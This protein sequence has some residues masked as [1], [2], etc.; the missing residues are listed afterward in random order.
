[1]VHGALIEA[2]KVEKLTYKQ[3]LRLERE[4]RKKAR[5]LKTLE[6]LQAAAEA[7]GRAAQGLFSNQITGTATFIL[8]A[9]TLYPA[10]L[11]IVET[12]LAELVTAIS[13]AWKSG[14]LPPPPP[15]TIQAGEGNFGVTIAEA[16]WARFVNLFNPFGQVANLVDGTSWFQ[17]AQERD[18]YYDSLVKTPGVTAFYNI[19][20]VNR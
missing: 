4:D 18:S 20:K 17:T 6:V 13:N 3:V 10:W 9:A 11:P 7:G 1:M 19:T 5:E 16:Q 15:L 8:I 14:Q 2:G 12:S